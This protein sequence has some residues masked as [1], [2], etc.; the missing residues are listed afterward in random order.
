MNGAGQLFVVATPIGHLEDLSQR[1][2][3]VL[4]RVDLIAAEDTRRT[5]KLLARLGLKATLV[6]YHEHNQVRVGRR[7]IKALSAGQDVALVTDAGTP[8]LSDPGPGLV[9][10]AAEAG[11]K[12]IPVPGP[13]ALAAALSVSGFPADRFTFVGFLPNKTAARRRLLSGLADR[14]EPLV[15]Y[16]AP[17]RLAASLEDLSAVLGPRPAVLCREL[18]KIH[19]EIRRSDL[20]QLAAWASQSQVKGEVTLVVSGAAKHRSDV[21]AV[22]VAQAWFELRGQGWSPSR[23]AKELAGRFNLPRAE[24]Y[25]LG[26]DCENQKK[27]A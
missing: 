23:T 22:A 2:K 4:S 1:A 9:A 25:R 10:S 3:D 5:R 15:F 13:S 19:E 14:A 11:V 26:L 17:H 20:G 21:S 16:E 6:S 7:L 18:T 27:S 24:I 12:I 8:G